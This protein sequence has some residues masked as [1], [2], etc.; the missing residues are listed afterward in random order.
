MPTDT[1]PLLGLL[2]CSWSM[3]GLG[4]SEDILARVIGGSHKDDVQVIK[5]RYDA[6]YSRSTLPRLEM[7]LRI[8]ADMLP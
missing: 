7:S 4:T 6:K 5:Q 3:E 1:C 8:S 2:R